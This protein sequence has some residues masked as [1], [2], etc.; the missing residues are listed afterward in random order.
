MESETRSWAVRLLAVDLDGTLL[1]DERRLTEDGADAI[2]RA[3]K[4]GVIVALASGRI[5]PSMRPFA[6][7][8][9]LQGPFVC[10]NGGH[11]I[12]PG[13]EELRFHSFDVGSREIIIDF[14]IAKQLHL[15]AY[16][17][18][19]LLFLQET[20][21]SQVYRSRVRSVIPRVAKINELLSTSISKMM[22]VGE[23]S[24]MQS[25]RQEIE[26][27]LNSEVT[28]VT[29]S[30]P[31]YLEFLS[32]D[33]HKGSGLAEVARVL[34]IRQEETAAIG[35]YLNDVEMLEWAG[36]S[37]AV[38]N[39]PQAARDAADVLVESNEKGGVARFIDSY[40]L[41]RQE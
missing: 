26:P 24:Q 11:V 22:L 35:D 5:Y 31:E 10:A 1:D 25:L 4:Q 39:A 41:N 3:T 7:A 17:R 37:A 23:P 34:G 14:A 38:E 19:E 2:R 36:I 21:W 28:R 32:P 9:G 20:P 13:G 40:V 27:M 6:E 30:E 15:N 29:E 8:L 12:G 18:E 16:T 33:A